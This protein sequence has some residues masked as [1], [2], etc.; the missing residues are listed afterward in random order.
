MLSQ[1]RILG[2]DKV[3][4]G[5]SLLILAYLSL[6][7]LFAVILS[8][9]CLN[10]RFEKKN[11]C[12]TF[13]CDEIVVVVMCFCRTLTYIVEHHFVKYRTFL[14][15]VEQRFVAYRTFSYTSIFVP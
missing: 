14:W 7:R 4:I 11:T 2:C 3:R 15:I 12:K 10:L 8:F 1:L 5:N 9:S 13:V 6:S